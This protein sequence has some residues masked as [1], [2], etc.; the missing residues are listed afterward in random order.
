MERRIGADGARSDKR[1]G[2]YKSGDGE[3]RDKNRARRNKERQTGRTIKK[4]KGEIGG[5][6]T[7]ADIPP[8]AEIGHGVNANSSTETTSRAQRTTEWLFLTIATFSE[9]TTG[10]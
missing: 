8:E 7:E 3:A 5:E 6:K 2:D 9:G 4:G 1:S 10:P